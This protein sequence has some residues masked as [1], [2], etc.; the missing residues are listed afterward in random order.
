L[1][2]QL[3]FCYI[4][5]VPLLVSFALIHYAVTGVLDAL[6]ICFLVCYTA[7]TI[8]AMY[9]YGNFSLYAIYLYTSFFFVYSRVF[10]DFIDYKSFL[11]ISFPVQ[12][13]F[14]THTGLVFLLVSLL[15]YYVIDIVF[16]L[17][18]SGRQPVNN[19][20]SNIKLQHIGI[21]L[22]CISMPPLI[23]K[24]YIRLLFVK[25]HGYLSVYNGMLDDLELPLWTRGT[26]TIFVLG[27]MLFVMGYPREKRFV[28]LSVVFLL[29]SA[30]NGM[31]GTRS[32]F[33][34]D[35][36]TVFYFY[37][38]LYNKKIKFKN[39]VLLLTGIVMFGSIVG[40]TRE[41]TG[42]N[43]KIGNLIKGF[44]YDQGTTIA[45]PLARIDSDGDIKYRHYPFIFSPMINPFLDLYYGDKVNLK[46]KL[47]K[48]H[49]FGT[50]TIHKYAPELYYKGMGLGGSV[51]MEMYD[52]G[53]V[54]GIVFWS[55]LL[56]W[57]ISS[58]ELNLKK[59]YLNIPLFWFIVLSVAYLPRYYF[60]GIIERTH[61]ILLPFIFLFFLKLII[62]PKNL[63]S[64]V[65]QPLPH[66]TNETHT[67]PY[68]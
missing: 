49:Y 61:H 18:R 32:S 54:S 62:W 16:S 53:G 24:G 30:L 68:G 56:A 28:F 14:N 46:I 50:I 66:R 65:R 58:V 12:H 51:L 20:H 67:F 27:Y 6:V 15:S 39:M 4:I 34:L 13:I 19:L 5:L 1:K 7:T 35:L 33:L 63:L 57:I 29:N 55:A 52:C 23:Y 37:V 42:I 43:E 31:K 26:G 45:V 11:Q 17:N 2:K 36:V 44:F 22:M 40:H 25:E 59:T 10:F 41:N 9:Y 47:K 60:F 64:A 21:F 8:K 48:Y 38:A 3:F